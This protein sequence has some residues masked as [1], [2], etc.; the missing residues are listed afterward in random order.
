[1]SEAT[2][3]TLYQRTGIFWWVYD[4]LASCFEI[5]LY[6]LLWDWWQPT[7]T[8]GKMI[9]LPLKWV[10]AFVAFPGTLTVTA[11]AYAWWTGAVAL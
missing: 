5:A 9:K 6:L 11:M 7:S 10:G 2:M 4:L 8:V 3:N 1:M